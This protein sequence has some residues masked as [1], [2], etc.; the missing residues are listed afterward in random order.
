ME[1]EKAMTKKVPEVELISGRK[2]PAIGMGTAVTPIPPSES[3]VSSF[4]DAI[5]VG[6]RHFDTASLYGTEE[7]LGKAV[8][9]AVEKGLVN[10]R[11]ELFITSKLWVTH[12]HPDLVLPSLQT[13]LQRLGMEYVDLYVVHWPVSVRKGAEA[14]G[15][16]KEEIVELD[17]KG[18]WQAMEECHQKGM[19]KTI[20]VSNFGPAKL[21]QL[22][23]HA[24]I[25]PAVNQVALRWIYE[26]GA[27]PI[28]KSFN[29]G[30][31]MQN[32]DIFDWELTNDEISQIEQIPQQ[33]GFSGEMFVSETGPYKTVDEL[34]DHPFKNISDQSIT[35]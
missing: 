32:L 34:W 4:L 20:G 19:A 31:M 6:Y 24:T 23:H 12:A 35:N 16:G 2:M 11:D 27:I 21:T 15:F 1:A 29:K 26:Q 10:S 5:R 9:E 28:V 25:A 18:T 22:L 7:S 14:L 30:R 3:L 17:M 33:R 8:A 13:T